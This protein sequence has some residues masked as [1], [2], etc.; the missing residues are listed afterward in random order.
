MVDSEPILARAPRN[1]GDA[2]VEA[3]MWQALASPRV[4][5][6]IEYGAGTGALCQQLLAAAP[7]ID[8]GFAAA[9]HYEIVERSAFLRARQEER[10]AEARDQVRW[11]GPDD[12]V[13]PAVGC[14]LSNEVADALPVHRVLFGPDAP[15]ELY[16]GL[17]AD[18]Y[19]ELR[20]PL[21]P[22][23]A[24]RLTGVRAPVGS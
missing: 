18:R 9:L 12:P 17:A 24:E 21:S 13:A 6:F 8:P 4:F 2:R 1:R 5:R 11:L 23:L 19:L 20:G 7:E 14:V 16:V 22:G 3:R 15:R 10:L